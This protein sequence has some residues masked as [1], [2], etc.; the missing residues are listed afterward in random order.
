VDARHTLASVGAST[1]VL[2][3]LVLVS[4][5]YVWADAL[6]AM[7][8]AGFIAKIGIDAVVEN[9]P[10]L[11]DRAP[12]SASAIGSVVNSVE[13]VTSFHRVRSRG[14]DDNI[15][16]DLHVRVDPKLSMRDANAIADE[17]RRRLL[18]LPG[19]RDV[20][21]HA[22]AQRHH[23]DAADVYAATRL[24][25]QELNIAIHEWWLQEDD[26]Q[27]DI[28]LHA[29]V[30]PSLTLEEAH[31]LVDRLESSVLA[32]QSQLDAVHTHIELANLDVLPSARVSTS[33]QKRVERALNEA[34]TEVPQLTDLRNIRVRQVEG[35]L[36]IT[37]EATVDG[38]L[39]VSEAHDLSTELQ[40]LARS[41]IANVRDVSIHLEPGAAPAVVNGNRPIAPNQAPK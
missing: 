37:A 6:V 41:Q 18:L 26:G 22:E 30:D 34:A 29:G 12:V 35:Q 38:S 32:R 14:P 9:V 8:V 28:V 17:V 2:L 36:F 27:L 7:L 40:E 39:S 5:G 19:V 4:A 15:A 24:A 3:G 31:A 10:A 11:V 20:T 1:A 21:V 13:G 25:A 23:E 33:L 16:V